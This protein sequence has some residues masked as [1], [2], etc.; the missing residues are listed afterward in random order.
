MNGPVLVDVDGTITFWQNSR[1]RLRPGIVLLFSALV[2]L[3]HRIVVWSAGGAE[4]AEFTCERYGLTPLV[5]AYYTKPEYPMEL[6]DLVSLV[7]TPALQIDDD[8]S[9]YPEG[10]TW[11]FMELNGGMA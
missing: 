4:Y 8:A 11:P 7:G 10:A 3:K 2:N 5:D 9:E 1:P 6:G